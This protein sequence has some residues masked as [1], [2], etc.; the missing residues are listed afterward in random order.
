M[1][2]PFI[3]VTKTKHIIWDRAPDL[4]LKFTDRKLLKQRIDFVI[5]NTL[6][7]L[8]W[9]PSWKKENWDIFYGGR[10]KTPL[11]GN[12]ANPFEIL[13]HFSRE[14][15]RWMHRLAGECQQRS[16]CE[17]CHIVVHLINC[18]PLQRHSLSR[19]LKRIPLKGFNYPNERLCFDLTRWFPTPVHLPA[20]HPRSKLLF[21]ALNTAFLSLGTERHQRIPINCQ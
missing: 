6:Q 4:L 8:Y 16:F 13:C 3:A 17:L 12:R 9:G 20:C 10:E 11:V 19:R 2:H 7:D 5:S 18:P 21:T 1:L 15:G 14:Q